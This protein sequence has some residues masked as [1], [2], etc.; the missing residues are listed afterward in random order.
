MERGD[1]ERG[2]TRLEGFIDQESGFS[3]KCRR[4]L[5]TFMQV[6]DS[7]QIYISGEWPGRAAESTS[8]ETVPASR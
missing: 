2:R 1:R 7:D 4:R 8:V 3:S 5:R 6:S